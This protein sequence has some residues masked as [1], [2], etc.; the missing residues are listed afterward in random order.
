MNALKKILVPV[1]FSESSIAALK[2]AAGMIK[3]DNSTKCDLIYIIG[4][5]VEAEYDL[6]ETQKKLES[7][8][9][10]YLT[11]LHIEGE[12]FVKVG[13]LSEELLAVKESTKA[14][15]II[16]GT[17]GSSTGLNESHTTQLLKKADCPVLVIPQNVASFELKN[18]ALAIDQKEIEDSNSLGILHNIARWFDAKI[19]LLT[20]DNNTDGTSNSSNPNEETLE[21]YLDTLDYRHS[22]AHNSDIEAGI[23]SYVAD[24]K[25]NMIAIMPR[26]HAKKSE[27][28][29]GQL[30]KILALNTTKPLLV[31]D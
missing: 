22:F 20:V 18:I 27:P 9:D 5:S 15:L 7:L 23:N 17:A 30:T 3:S 19:H 10:K 12:L 29:E 6:K 8:K 21:Y 24:K 11:P 1:D 28:S 25:I 26:H 16:M 13:K 2:Y 4:K 31:I 14:D